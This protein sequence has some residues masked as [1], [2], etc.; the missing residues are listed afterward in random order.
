MRQS[1]KAADARCPFYLG[2]D[3][4]REVRCEGF[5]EGMTVQLRFRKMVQQQEFMGLH[6]CGRYSMCELYKATMKKYPT[7]F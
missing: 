5:T 2:D 6:C 3:S 4:K 1:W 7:D